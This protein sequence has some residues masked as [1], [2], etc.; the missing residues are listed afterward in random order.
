MVI[1]KGKMK[2][3][4]RKAFVREIRGIEENEKTCKEQKY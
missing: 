2:E 1:K 4:D 3:E